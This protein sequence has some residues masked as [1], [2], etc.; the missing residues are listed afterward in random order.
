MINRSYV[1]GYTLFPKWYGRFKTKFKVFSDY[2]GAYNFY[3]SLMTENKCFYKQVFKEELKAS[4]EDFTKNKI[5]LK[6]KVNMI[7]YKDISQGED[8]DE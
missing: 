1:V 7:Y 8:K 3:K 6:P 4:E 2:K 5:I